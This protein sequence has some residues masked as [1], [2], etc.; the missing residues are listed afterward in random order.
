MLIDGDPGEGPTWGMTKSYYEIYDKKDLLVRR[1]ET[2][3]KAAKYLGVS[4]NTFL[5]GLHNN[6]YMYPTFEYRIVKIT[7]GGPTVGGVRGVCV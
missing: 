5:K 3:G 6:K 7:N 1:F 2:W 4:K